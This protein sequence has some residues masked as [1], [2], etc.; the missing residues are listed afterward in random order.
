MA[1]YKTTRTVDL[2]E[3]TRSCCWGTAPGVRMFLHRA[4]RPKFFVAAGHRHA[5]GEVLKAA[6]HVCPSRSLIY[7]L[8]HPCHLEANPRLPPDPYSKIRE[9]VRRQAEMLER[10]I[11]HGCSFSEESPFD[12]I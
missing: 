9:S 7:L 12:Y 10:E 5:S 3:P 11:R 1:T 4:W 8:R 2:R 6:R